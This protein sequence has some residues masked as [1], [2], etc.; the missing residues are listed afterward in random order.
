MNEPI[1]CTPKRLPQSKWISA[2]KTAS[3]INPLNHPPI[4]RLTRIMPSFAPDKLKISVL[5]TKYWKTGGVNLTVGFMDNPPKNLQKRIL[6]HLNAWNTSAKIKFVASN[7]DPQVRIART[8]DDGHWSYLGTDVLLIPK[9]EPT[10]NL[11]S[12]TMQTPDSEFFRVVRHEAGHTIGCPHEHM[13]R[14]LVKKIDEQKAI[15]FYGA[16]Q[17]WS[18][19]EVKQQVLTPIEESSLWGTLHTDPNSIMCYQIP[20]SITKDGQPIL[21]GL[22]INQQD[23]DFLALVYPKA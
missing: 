14:Q 17:G 2:A 18:E 19:Q 15:A 8:P 22:D 4:E 10:M 9:N 20:G 3:E 13:R 6:S 16:T 11:D 21:G 1:V 5:T 12:F 23:H 7:T